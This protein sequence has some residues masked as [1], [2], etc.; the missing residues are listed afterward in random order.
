MPK[1]QLK[2]GATYSTCPHFFDNANTDLDN[3]SL[4]KS[5]WPTWIPHDDFSAGS[6]VIDC[7]DSHLNFLAPIVISD[8]VLNY[9]ANS[10]MQILR[11]FPQMMLRRETLPPFIHGHWYRSSSVSQ[12]ALP[13][14]LGTC[15]GIAQVFTSYNP[16]TRSY[17][18]HT[19]KTEQRSSIYKV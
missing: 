19:V 17:L 2:F 3:V 7:S 5:P 11:A 8:P 6:G 4:M 14:P 16:E 10:I 13:S 15:M 18:W 12:P 1:W 9:T